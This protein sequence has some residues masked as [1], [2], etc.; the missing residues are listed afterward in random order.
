M[1][2]RGVKYGIKKCK[3]PIPG[4]CANCGD[5]STTLFWP[6]WKGAAALL[7]SHWSLR[8]KAWS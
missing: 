8:H 4:W 6:S 1:G 3:E 5:C 2:E 7:A